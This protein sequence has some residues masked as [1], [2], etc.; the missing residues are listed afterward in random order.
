MKI[1]PHQVCNTSLHD[2]W[3]VT[4]HVDS[5]ALNVTNVTYS[6]ML[7]MLNVT[8]AHMQSPCD[9][10]S[11]DCQRVKIQYCDTEFY[12]VVCWSI[13]I[14]VLHVLMLVLLWL[15]TSL[16]ILHLPYFCFIYEEGLNSIYISPDATYNVFCEAL[17]SNL[18]F[19]WIVIS[20]WR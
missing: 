13:W 3:F 20:N 5:L 14:S 16:W 12:F 17:D 7:E 11:F 18:W 8:S 15:V 19:C 4:L 2:K 10:W 1:I 9:F 6:V